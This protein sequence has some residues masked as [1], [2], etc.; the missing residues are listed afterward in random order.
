MKLPK[1]SKFFPIDETL[2]DLY[3]GWLEGPFFKISFHDGTRG[4]LIEKANQF[5]KEN[6]FETVI[7]E[8]DFEDD[9]EIEIDLIIFSFKVLGPNVLLLNFEQPLMSKPIDSLIELVTLFRDE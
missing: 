1:L 3:G 9:L 2:A 7:T 4:E 6:G 5:L 8:S